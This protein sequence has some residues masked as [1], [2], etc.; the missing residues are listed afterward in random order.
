[1]SIRLCLESAYE[2]SNSC[3]RCMKRNFSEVFSNPQ[4]Y[5]SV[6]GLLLYYTEEDKCLILT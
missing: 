6:S 1:M 4:V 3:T 2:V 5:I